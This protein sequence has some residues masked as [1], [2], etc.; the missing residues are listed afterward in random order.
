MRASHPMHVHLYKVMPDK[1]LHPLEG[2]RA[3]LTRSSLED[4]VRQLGYQE[5][6]LDEAIR[7]DRH[8]PTW[9]IA[10]CKFRGECPGLAKRDTPSKSMNLDVDE[11]FRNGHPEYEF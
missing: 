5:F 6:R 10:V 4:R 9:R 8:W 3:Q 2:M 1:N 11:E 7:P